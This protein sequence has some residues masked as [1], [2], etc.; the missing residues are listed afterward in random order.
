MDIVEAIKSRQ[1]CRRF[2]DQPVPLETMREILDIAR[3]AP[4][5]SNVQPQHIHVLAGD[6]LQGLVDRVLEQDHLFPW[7]DGSAYP[8]HP[9]DLDDPYRAR[10]YACANSMYS[11][12]GIERSDR[13]GRVGQFVENFRFFRAP[14]GMILTIDRNM[15]LGQW[16]DLGI[17]IQTIMLAARGFGLHTCPQQAWTRWPKTVTE[18]L[19]IPDHRMIYSGLA[20]GYM[21]EGHPINQWRTERQAVEDFAT[22]EGFDTASPRPAKTR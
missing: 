17:F 18:Y 10:Q 1:S 3:W 2:T 16:G 22:F 14:V 20:L 11:S 8:L 13:A 4:S 12:V 15:G 21:D 9:P 6:R 5:G 19:Q 7:G